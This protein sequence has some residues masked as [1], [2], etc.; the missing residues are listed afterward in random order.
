MTAVFKKYDNEKKGYLV[1]DEFIAF[2]ENAG[3]EREETVWMNLK[4]L[5]YGP[6]LNR[7]D[8]MKAIISSIETVATKL[9]RYILSNNP[10]CFSLLFDLMSKPTSFIS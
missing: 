5:G 3:R 9:P 10:K 6:D 2:Y 7:I 8:G 1:L 4:E